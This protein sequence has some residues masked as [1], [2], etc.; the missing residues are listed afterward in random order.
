M[1]Q[2]FF[3]NRLPFRS[4]VA[5]RPLFSFVILDLVGLLILGC[6]LAFPV[7]LSAGAWFYV[8][9]LATLIPLL[10]GGL[11]IGSALL[12]LGKITPS[13]ASRF[14]LALGLGLLSTALLLLAVS[15]L[16]RLSA[17]GAFAVVLSGATLLAMLFA[18]GERGDLRHAVRNWGFIAAICALSIVWSWQAVMSVPT[19][20]GTHTFTAWI[21]F[22]FH[23]AMVSQF[24]HF[25]DFGGTWIYAQG[26]SLPIYHYAPYML[27]AV[28][29]AVTGAPAIT[30]ATAFGST[31]AFVI[32]GLSVWALGDAL[33]GP[34][35]AAAALGAVYI[36]PNA[37]LYGFKNPYYDFHW[38]LQITTSAQAVGLGVLAI[39][40]AILAVRNACWRT[41]LVAAVLALGVS[42][43]KAQMLPAMGLAGLAFLLLYWSFRYRWLPWAV[44]AA[45][46]VVGVIG[47]TAISL[48]P[49]G[50]ALLQEQWDP[51]RTLAAMLLRDRPIGDGWPQF[52][53]VPIL[54]GIV[55]L[56]A[57]GALLPAY[58]IGALWC[59][60]WKLDRRFDLLPLMF[61]LAYSAV[62]LTFPI[63][64][65]DEFQH[66]PFPLIYVVL[67]VW[68]ACL[69]VRMLEAR[70]PRLASP[71]LLVAG[72]LLL[73]LP[74]AMQRTAQAGHAE[75]MNQFNHINIP[76]G[77]LRAAEFIKRNAA[78]SDVIVGS[79]SDG[80]VPVYGHLTS[81]SER[82]TYVMS[83]KSRLAW[84]LW[85]IP[86][87]MIARRE[88]VVGQ[89]R[90]AETIESLYRTAQDAGIS[91]F[92]LSPPD[93]FPD[94]LMAH[95]VF[96]AD[97]YAVFAIPR[98]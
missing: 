36:L 18:G 67:A 77:L 76:R 56:T 14:P 95:A 59:R 42:M 60:T 11:V 92:V 37:G 74:L 26:A 7:A 40:V 10:L 8:P 78:H 65:N 31:L 35:G 62:A 20:Q 53:A 46:V 94:A 34:R 30:I 90:Q 3:S 82:S 24:A 28:L 61:V 87:D 17:G 5:T 86:V 71:I 63:T 85:G 19:L 9:A 45:C 84:E 68:S 54:L 39:V 32:M 12:G 44:L 2:E 48:G 16:F 33:Q 79:G 57:F 55:L 51:A 22:F 1:A 47:L 4:L 29:D 83:L 6:A 66:R 50:P 25:A 27:P 97:G 72:L 38:L 89:L 41:G 96:S 80:E 98:R 69:L 52:I 81:L 93:R 13:A 70:L 88:A 23:S 91:W 73:P 43:F 49:R 15:L 21:D 75:W 58:A 64:K